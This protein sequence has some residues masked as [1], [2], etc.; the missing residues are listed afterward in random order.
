MERVRLPPLLQTE[1]VLEMLHRARL[2]II[3]L[4]L[5]AVVVT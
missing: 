3:P 5:D 1:E 4:L 2:H